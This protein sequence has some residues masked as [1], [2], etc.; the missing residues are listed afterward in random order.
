MTPDELLRLIN[1][2]ESPSLEFKRE[3]HRIFDPD[4][5]I[6]KRHRDEFIRD[7]LSLA[8]GNTTTAGEKAYLIIGVEDAYEPDKGR[9]VRGIT[10]RTPAQR[11]ILSIIRPASEPPVEDLVCE[12]VEIESKQVF[13]ITIFPSP[14]VHETTRNLSPVDGKF[15]S[16][17]VI[18]MRSGDSIQIASTKERQAIQDVKAFRYADSTKGNP[19]IVGGIVGSIV[20]GSVANTY[21]A[22]EELPSFQRGVVSIIWGLLGG[23]FGA[24][25]GNGYKSIFQYRRELQTVPKKW[26]IPLLSGTLTFGIGSM[27][28]VRRLLTP[29]LERI[30]LKQRS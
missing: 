7:L 30:S 17:Y 8:N 16:E 28:I 2:R 27:Y 10:G 9:E 12:T 24:V 29:L 26:R 11:E 18:F 13:V 6:Q 14:H 25:I 4:K 5:N 15:Y 23:L 22:K 20:G 1:Q 19:V 21:S 3:L